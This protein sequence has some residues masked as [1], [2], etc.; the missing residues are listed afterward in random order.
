[1]NFYLTPDPSPTPTRSSSPTTSSTTKP[2]STTPRPYTVTLTLARPPSTSPH[3]RASPAGPSTAASA[4]SSFPLSREDKQTPQSSPTPKPSP[5]TPTTTPK[6][7]LPTPYRSPLP[8]PS[9]T[10]QTDKR[11]QGIISLDVYALYSTNPVALLYVPPPK[12]KRTA[13][14]FHPYRR[15]VES[16]GGKEKEKEKEKETMQDAEKARHKEW[17]KGRKVHGSIPKIDVRSFRNTK[18]VQPVVWKKSASLTIPPTSPGYDLLTPEELRTCST[19]R[20]MP[21]QYLTVKE[22]LLGAVWRGPLKKREA[23]RWFRIDVNKTAVLYDWFKA[24][25]WIPGEEEW[26]E[27]RR[28]LV[29]TEKGIVVAA[30]WEGGGGGVG[31]GEVEAGE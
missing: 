22:T 24:L 5:N 8:L 27:H 1:M 4:S 10:S 21:S 26:A 7:K 28:G 11:A 25:G 6:R 2:P 13:A 16:G 31:R 30:G 23:K 12:K 14:L 19:L 20:M 17:D 15:E 18:G 9:T 3:N 29:E